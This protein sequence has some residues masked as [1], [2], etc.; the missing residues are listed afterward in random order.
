MSTH[1]IGFYEEM[2]K[3]IFQLS[4]NTLLNLFFCTFFMIYKQ[5]IIQVHKSAVFYMLNENS[6]IQ[7]QANV[8]M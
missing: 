5:L 2:T 6:Y 3:I 7:H 4:S 8:S 1:T